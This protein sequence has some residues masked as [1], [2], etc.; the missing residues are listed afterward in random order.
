MCLLCTLFQPWKYLLFIINLRTHK[1]CSKFVN[2][3]SGPLF[4]GLLISLVQ[5]GGEDA[6]CFVQDKKEFLKYSM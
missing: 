6:I 3:F 4:R 1:K 5:P 2:A